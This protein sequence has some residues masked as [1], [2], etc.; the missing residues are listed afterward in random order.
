MTVSKPPTQ[1]HVRW[2]GGK[3]TTSPV[4]VTAKE[5]EVNLDGSLK[6]IR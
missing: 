2:P 5:I 4:P 3:N 6:V 1:I